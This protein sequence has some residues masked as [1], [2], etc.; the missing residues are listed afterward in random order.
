M[1]N[2]AAKDQNGETYYRYNG[3]SN[4]VLFEENA[5]GAITKAYT[6]DDNGHPLTMI[7]E[8]KTYYYLTNYRGDV[9][10]MTDAGGAVVAEYSYDAWGNILTQSGTPEKIDS[11]N[12]YRYAGY[13]Y[14][15][16]TKLYYLMAR[17]YNLDTGVFPIP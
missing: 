16:Q 6:Y 14:D 11:I 2:R 4:Q 5:S 9:I 12:P 10:A 7:Y 8:G 13:R 17:Y 1:T 3:T 15:E